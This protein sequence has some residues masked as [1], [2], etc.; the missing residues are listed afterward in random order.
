MNKQTARDAL[1]VVRALCCGNFEA[2]DA[3]IDDMSGQECAELAVSL[4]SFAAVWAQL[5]A[6]DIDGGVERLIAVYLAGLQ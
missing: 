2:V 6:E 5:Y 1:G 4:A 3:V